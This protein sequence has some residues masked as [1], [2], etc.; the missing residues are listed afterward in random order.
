M[1]LCLVVLRETVDVEDD[2]FETK[3]AVAYRVLR[4]KDGVYW[5]ERYREDTNNGKTE[6]VVHEP[7]V[8]PTKADGSTFDFIP[9]TFFGPE[10]NDADMDASPM[11]SMATLNLA[12][13]RNSA[14]YEDACFIAGQPTPV[15]AGLTEEWVKNVMQGK[16]FLGSRG[17]IMLPKDGTAQ[18]LQA[19]PNTMWRSHGHAKE[20]DALHRL[21]SWGNVRS[22]ARQPKHRRM[23][24]PK[25][26]SCRARP[27]TSPQRIGRRSC[28]HRC[29]PQTPER[30]RLR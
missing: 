28:G 19:Q 8:T 12:H 13:Y 22:G 25:R 6:L 1:K 5:V 10:N 18:L 27:R 4:L 20:A 17:G 11:Y 23:R 2:G 9:F 24:H 3:T 29:L 14:D 7:P 30:S 16:A 21:Q 15:F 26:Q